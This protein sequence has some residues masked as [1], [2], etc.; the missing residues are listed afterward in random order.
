MSSGS[1]KLLFRLCVLLFFIAGGLLVAYSFG[2]KLDLASLTFSETGGIY[3]KSTP[4][5]AEI[6][7]NEKSIKNTSSFFQAGTI[8]DN[9]KEGEYSLVLHYNGYFD[10][11]KNV[12]VSPSLV[13]VFDS[14]VMIP[15]K[16]PIKI[17]EPADKIELLGDI[18]L[19]ERN[20]SIYADKV[21]VLGNNIVDIAP[22]DSVTTYN[23][24]TKD[25]YLISLSNPNSYLNIS[26]TFNNLKEGKLGLPGAVPILNVAFHP[27]NR[28]RIIVRSRGALYNI[29]IARSTI[30]KVAEGAS[31]FKT[32]G[33]NLFF[34]TSDG[35]YRYN[36]IFRTTAKLVPLS[37]LKTIKDFSG[38][39]SGEAIVLYQDGE[40]NL[41]S[42]GTPVKIADKAELF[43]ISDNGKLIAFGD[44]DQ[45]LHIY[46]IEKQKYADIKNGVAG[47]LNKIVWY[48]DNNH[49]LLQNDNSLYFSEISETVPVNCFK[50][51]SEVRNFSYNEDGNT[52]YINS[53]GGVLK[54]EI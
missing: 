36:L 9:L 14:V 37:N 10:W 40:L 7:L 28:D 44:N 26:D 30:E 51:A 1:R 22:N 19:T 15:Q 41:V 17:A 13:N 47:A 21:R 6:Y 35:F 45:S 43:T 34:Y 31:E 4:A 3:I 12:N 5:E 42:G 8:I 32:Q 33:N 50:I 2:I 39:P 48:K 38:T 20:G 49:L 16:E 46:D 54:Y 25:Y 52:V 11:Q 24:T 27:F 18:L 23:N 53:A 29:D